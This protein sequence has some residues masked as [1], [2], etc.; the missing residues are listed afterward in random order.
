MKKKIRAI[1][2]TSAALSPHK[3]DEMMVDDDGNIVPVA[4]DIAQHRNEISNILKR[5]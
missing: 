3:T 1:G 2:K 4:K 5:F